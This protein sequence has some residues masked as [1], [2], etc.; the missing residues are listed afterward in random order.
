MSQEEKK[1]AFE[2]FN[3][4][5]EEVSNA[6]ISELGDAIV[7][8]LDRADVQDV[9]A[10]LTGSFVSLTLELCRR[11]GCDT[12]KEIRL[13]GVGTRRDITIHAEKA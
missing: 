4:L 3:A 8:A 10:L 12:S 5:T 7:K 11:E 2:A 13:D 1:D 9:L 6:A